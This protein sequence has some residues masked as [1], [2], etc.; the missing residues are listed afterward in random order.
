MKVRIAS[1][2]NTEPALYDLEYK[3]WGFWHW[4]YR[5]SLVACWARAKDLPRLLRPRT[6]VKEFEI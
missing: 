2:P 6:I 1:V 4:N 5:G 3:R